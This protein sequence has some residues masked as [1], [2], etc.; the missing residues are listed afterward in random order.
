MHAS[1]AETIKASEPFSTVALGMLLLKER[2]SQLTFLSLVPICG[3]VAL[4]C[5]RFSTNNSELTGSGEAVSLTGA[6]SNLAAIGGFALAA[7]S[8]ICFSLRAVLAKQLCARQFAGLLD[9]TSLFHHISSIGLIALIPCALLFEGRQLLYNV[10]LMGNFHR[11]LT[12][13]LL[14]A[15]NGAAY[16]TYNLASFYV[17]SRSSV[18]VHAVLNVFRRVAIILVTAALFGVSLQSTNLAGIVVAVVGVCVF[19]I[20]RAREVMGSPRLAGPGTRDSRET[21]LLNSRD[22]VVS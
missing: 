8:N 15:V 7:S 20:A 6:A 10:L 13:S 4:A 2:Y 19:S 22:S 3:G 16:T 21:S 5:I 12:F 11:L 17:L 1:F 18:V 9:E 14:L